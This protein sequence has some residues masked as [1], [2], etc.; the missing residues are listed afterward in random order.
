MIGRGRLADAGDIGQRG[1][2]GIAAARQDL[3]PLRDQRAVD[4]G[5]RHHVADGPE[6]DQVEPRREVGLR[7]AGV[8]AA[9]AQGAVDRDHQQEGDADRGELLVRGGVV[10]AV[11][12]DDGVGRRQRRR[13]QMVVDDDHVEPRRGRL[14]ESVEGD[15]AA[16]QRH[17]HRRP[18]LTQPAQRRRV[19]AV[20]LGQAVGNVEAGVAADGAQEAQQ[21]RRGG[22]AVD[23]VVAEQGDPL[24][25]R[26]R[27]RQPRRRLVHARAG[28][29]DRAD[30]S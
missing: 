15:D 10:E 12:I 26:D 7:A 11:G 27:P 13:R 21:E 8:A 3:E 29:R 24:A 25:A 6:G 23:V 17:H 9:V 1:D 30:R 28:R 2:A 5:Q 18:F 16:I 19:G 22:G 20:A 4:A 14:G